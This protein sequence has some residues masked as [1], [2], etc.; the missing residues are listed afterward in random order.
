MRAHHL[1]VSNVHADAA[2]AAARSGRGA[3][4]PGRW[5]HATAVPDEQQRRAEGIRHVFGRVECPACAS[6]FSIADTYTSVNL[7]GV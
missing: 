1:S 3:S 5:M 6:V 4:R 7:F 2:G